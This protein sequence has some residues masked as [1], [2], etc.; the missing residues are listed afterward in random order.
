MNDEIQ[1]A[2]TLLRV[3]VLIGARALIYAVVMA[4]VWAPILAWLLRRSR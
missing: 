3:V 4:L 2:D 1:M